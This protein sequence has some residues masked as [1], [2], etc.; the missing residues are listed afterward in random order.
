MFLKITD[1]YSTG[2]I[3][4]SIIIPVIKIKVIK[5]CYHSGS[6]TKIPYAAVHMDNGE[7]YVSR[8]TIISLESDLLKRNILI[9]V[10]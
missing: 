3:P 2:N 10:D 8:E 4:E 7:V 5:T 6:G 1:H 9:E